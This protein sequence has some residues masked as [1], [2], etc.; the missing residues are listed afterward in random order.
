MSKF[1]QARRSEKS[2][3]YRKAAAQYASS[4]FDG[5]V[6]CNFEAG[7][8]MRIELG[9]LLMAISCDARANNDHRAKHIFD[10][11]E[12]LLQEIARNADSQVLVGLAKEWTG[13]GLLMLGSSE[14]IELYREADDHYD[15][16]K[17]GERS[18]GHE[19]EF[20]YAY[21][22]VESFL[23]EYGFEFPD[24]PHMPLQFT[25]R[26]KFKIRTAEEILD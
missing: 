14:A 26:I 25:E 24:E 2:G 12:R 23:K 10:I 9:V 22:A 4:G 15:D 16:L 11:V 18:W 20:H 17:W 6:D 8:R 21:I 1:E 7:R 19:Q 13:D 5:L 3:D